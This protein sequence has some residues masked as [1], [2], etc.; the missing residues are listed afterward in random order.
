[1]PI[2][3]LPVTLSVH[4]PDEAARENLYQEFAPML[5]T[6]RQMFPGP[7]LLGSSLIHFRHSIP[8]EQARLFNQLLHPEAK[9][10]TPPFAHL[11]GRSVLLL[12][13]ASYELVWQG[14]ARVRW[15]NAIRKV[16][17]RTFTFILK[18]WCP[19][20]EGQELNKDFY[21]GN[22][23]NE[24]IGR[25][26]SVLILGGNGKADRGTFLAKLRRPW[27]NWVFAR[28][29]LAQKTSLYFPE[30]LLVT[31]A[32]ILRAVAQQIVEGFRLWFWA[33]Q[34]ESLAL[35]RIAVA[36]SIDLL[37]PYTT[38]NMLHYAIGYAAGKFFSPRACLH[39]YEGKP[40]ESLFRL[41]ARTAN[42]SCRLVGYQHTIVMPHS[43][44]VTEPDL[45]PA[46][47]GAP[48]VV[49]CLGPGTVD[50]LTPGHAT[51]RTTLIPFGS[52]R[53]SLSEEQL[54]QPQR[55]TVLVLPEGIPSE[56]ILLFNFAMK[57]A[58]ALPD[59]HFVFRSHPVLPF[60]TV[61][62]LLD[63]APRSQMNIELSTQAVIQ[64]DYA[65]ASVILYRGSS[66]V[67]Y[68]ILQG[69]KPLYFDAPDTSNIDPLYA[70]STWRETAQ[71]VHSATALLQRYAVNS[72]SGVQADWGVAR[73]FASRY[74]IPVTAESIDQFLAT[75]FASGG[76]L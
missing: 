31:S 65:R 61:R 52:F 16:Q 7:A 32:S 62:P 30:H 4:S 51:H 72:P 17:S 48:D 19:Q 18:T 55:R 42:P 74:T 2:S 3:S 57:L 8:D 53:F 46:E 68:A 15:H 75:Q 14:L 69:A 41:G 44:E 38:Q 37:R 45:T 54:P 66:T 47:G 26:E 49:L 71:D 28:Q 10:S 21:W 11:L 73:D 20:S 9:A 58:A 5:R 36:T 22:L 59:H 6:L 50:L 39:L 27:E 1:M 67:L 23:A 34:T 63:Q 12:L 70:L 76:S 29:L 64:A 56:A 43:L 60:E 24:L 35:K 13:S 33:Q 40:W 25:G